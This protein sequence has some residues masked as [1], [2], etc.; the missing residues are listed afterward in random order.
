MA[1]LEILIKGK[2]ANAVEILRRITGKKEPMDVC[3]MALRVLEWCLAQQAL[4]RKIVSEDAIDP[5][6]KS[7][8]LV[9]YVH[10]RSLALSFFEGRDIFQ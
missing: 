1:E 2:A 9:D 3:I 4:G 6:G 10:D 8:E 5:K 7:I